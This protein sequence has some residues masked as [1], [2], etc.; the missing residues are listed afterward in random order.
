MPAFERELCRIGEKRQDR[1]IDIKDLDYSAGVMH[2][3]DESEAMTLTD[4]SLRQFASYLDIPIAAMNKFSKDEKTK[5]HWDEIVWTQMERKPWPRLL[6]VLDGHVQGFVS[7]RF[8]IGYDA[9]RTFPAL[10]DA[11]SV[12]GLNIESAAVTGE[13]AYIKALSRRVTGAVLHQPVQFGLCLSTSDVGLSRH[14]ASLLIY[15]LECLN[16]MIVASVDCQLSHTHRGRS[17]WRND[18]GE[19]DGEADPEKIE[20]AI[21]TMGIDMVKLLDERNIGR[22]IE[23]INGV[24]EAR[25]PRDEKKL[26]PALRKA[27][28]SPRGETDIVLSHLA[29]N[30]RYTLWGL[31]SAITR[32]AQDVGSYDRATQLEAIGWKVIANPPS[33]KDETEATIDLSELLN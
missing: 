20:A 3:K 5:Q 29:Q 28:I 18:D 32:T 21:A 2:H 22:I 6:R 27:G 25:I 26:E 15:T 9:H 17:L 19:L 8:N 4:H 7:T 11:L 1:I 14:R 10:M 30:N 12:S 16:G 31:S 33:F 24:A 13:H 23:Q